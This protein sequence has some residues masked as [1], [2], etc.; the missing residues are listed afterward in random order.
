ME[1][2]IQVNDEGGLEPLLAESW[3]VSEDGLTYVF[4]LREGVKWHDGSDL[5]L[6]DVIWT[7]EHGRTEGNVQSCIIN[8][9]PVGRNVDETLR[10]IQAFQYHAQ[11][12]EAAGAR[13]PASRE[14]S[15]LSRMLAMDMITAMRSQCAAM[16]E[17]L[18]ATGRRGM[19]PR[20]TSNRQTATLG[21]L[22]Q[23]GLSQKA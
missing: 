21:P 20:D 11:H 22:S 4:N 6:D 7:F 10:V 5:T 17:C 16:S 8:N 15:S 13:P 1:T 19:R 3:D 14:A 23:N 9:L 18:C 2:L 12:G